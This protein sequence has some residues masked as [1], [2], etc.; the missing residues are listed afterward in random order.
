MRGRDPILLLTLVA[1]FG[2]AAALAP[3]ET[4]AALAIALIGLLRARLITRARLWLLAA[5][6]LVSAARGCGAKLDADARYET[7]RALTSPPRWCDLE[8]TVAS[9]PQAS[10]GTF[11]FV[12]SVERGRCGDALVPEGMR[13]DLRAT[14]STLA[15]G[16][17]L[18]VGG[19]LAPI[20]LFDNPGLT[21]G[22]VRVARTG[23]AMS[24]RADALELIEPGS[25]I[26]CAVDHARAHVRER[27]EATYHPEAR[28]LGRALVLGETDLDEEVSEAFRATG[29][30]H[31]LAVSGTHLIVAVMGVA[32]ALRALLLRIDRLAQRLDVERVAAL[33]AIPLAWAYAD[34]AGGS[35]SVLRA[36]AM[37][38]GGLAARLVARKP[39]TARALAVALGFGVAEDPLAIADISF[40][41]STA[42]TAGLLLL[43]R[44][45]AHLL[46]AREPTEE[47]GLLRRGW[48][49][50]A[51][52]ISTTLAATLA[53]APV[54]ACLSSELPVAGVFANLFAAPLGETMALPFAMGHVALSPFPTLELG[55]ARVASGA[56]RGVLWVARIA[57]DVGLSLPVPAPTAWQLAAVGAGTTLV[58]SLGTRAGK[59]W[60]T[61]VIAGALVALELGFRAAARPEGELRVTVLDVGQGDSILVDLPDGSLMLIDG[62]GFPG[63]AF[64]VGKRVLVPVLR[65]RRR[66]HIDRVIV[67]H[68]HPDHFGGLGAAVESVSG[69]DELWDNGRVEEHPAR[70]LVQL[71]KAVETKGG[72][73]VRPDELCGAPRD[74]GGAV[75]ELL[76][77]CPSLDP[78][79]STN[80]GSLVLRIRY[81]NR[82]VLLMGDAEEAAEERLLASGADLRADL[83]KVGHHGSRTSSTPE[84]I[85]AVKPSIAVISCG[86]RN[87][88]GHP[89]G[90]ALRTLEDADASIVRTDV[91]GAFVFSTDGD[92][93]SVSRR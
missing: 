78:E 89:H 41:L 16:D 66:S 37:L 10:A 79:L 60:G 22:W 76:A 58:L 15:R 84:L 65:A 69:V 31:V 77:P 88:F 19:T 52:A 28:A 44:P 63:Q 91:G 82:T 72:R 40:T 43:S 23:V 54:T 13:I 57:R 47:T 71:M 75:V 73:I 80:D 62:G 18:Q 20:S 21:P 50:F 90:R 48:S 93:V 59:L 7:A 6:S 17:R 56:L 39:C 33:A 36:A 3:I 24:G 67:T 30:S 83:L 5:A 81:K 45:I 11:R 46:G 61:L 86:A 1:Y 51:T 85:E 70:E 68:P 87:R 42:A 9:S 34:F 27:I 92:R 14:S 64:D 12:L 38:T 4:G 32:T 55:A 49:L 25:G 53:C 29:L 35:G 26:S 8:G 2:G 74:Y